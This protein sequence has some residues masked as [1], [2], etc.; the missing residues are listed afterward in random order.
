MTRCI[1]HYQELIDQ[2]HSPRH[3]DFASRLCQRLRLFSGVT[4]MKRIELL[5]G[6]FA[7][8]EVWRGTSKEVPEWYEYESVS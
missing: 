4:E 8:I 3:P 5:S 1:L 6:G 7:E 2:G